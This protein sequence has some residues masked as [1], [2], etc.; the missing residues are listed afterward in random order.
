MEGK[1]TLASKFFFYLGISPHL[2]S[3][4]RPRLDQST[5]S[6]VSSGV[7][8]V[9]GVDLSASMLALDMSPRSKRTKHPTGCGQR[10]DTG[11]Y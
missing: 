1:T 8:I 3:I 10:C 6:I 5:Q 9:L 4:S 2:L 7:D 11:I